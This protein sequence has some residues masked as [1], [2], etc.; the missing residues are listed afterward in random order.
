[1]VE[2]LALEWHPDAL[3]PPFPW[4]VALP[5]DWAVL[6]THPARWERQN[7]RIADDAFAGRR[8][9]ARQRRALVDAL[10]DAVAQAQRQKVLI[11]LVRPGVTEDGEVANTVLNLAFSDSSPRMASLAPVRQAFGGQEAAAEERTTPDGNGYAVVNRSS[12]HVVDGITRRLRTVQG[13]YPFAGTPWTLILSATA[14]RAGADRRQDP[15]D[16]L[17]DLV[18]RCAHS[19]SWGETETRS[20]PPAGAG[21]VELA[22]R[23]FDR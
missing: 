5:S 13:F 8:M 6:D 2:E 1:M 21:G 3:R 9:P 22:M 23:N 14:S 18:V 16:A 15:T 17:N 7:A 20:V 10:A 4:R 19:V 12:A 11:T